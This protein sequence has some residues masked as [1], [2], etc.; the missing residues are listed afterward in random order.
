MISM[1]L[2]GIAGLLYGIDIGT[3]SIV[4]MVVSIAAFAFLLISKQ[5]FR[6]IDDHIARRNRA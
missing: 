3:T 4:L 5:P 2:Y 1:A 6:L